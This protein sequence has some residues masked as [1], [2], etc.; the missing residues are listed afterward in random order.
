MEESPEAKPED[1]KEAPENREAEPLLE[2]SVSCTQ[3]RS[4]VAANI[5]TSLIDSSRS[6]RTLMAEAVWV[7][8]IITASVVVMIVRGTSC[9]KPLAV[10][11]SIYCGYLLV[12]LCI[13]YLAVMRVERQVRN[14]ALARCGLYSAGFLALMFEIAWMILGNVWVYKADDCSNGIWGMT[15]TLVIIWYVKLAIPVLLC[16]LLCL[17]VPVLLLVMRYVGPSGAVPATEVRTT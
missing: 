11:L 9:D 12:A 17:S 14:R 6:E 4:Q 5:R 16:L 3:A 10:W 2:G 15:L 1:S 7:F 8:L 13:D